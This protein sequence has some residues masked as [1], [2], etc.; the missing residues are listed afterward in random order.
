MR[1]TL[2][3]GQLGYLTIVIAP[4]VYTSLPGM[5]LFIRLTDLGIF[6]VKQ[7]PLPPPTCTKPIPDR[8]VITNADMT[9]PKVNFTNSIWLY[10]KCHVVEL[11]LRNQI[12]DALEP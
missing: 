7:A 9:I 2:D 8:S 1:T 3:R 4:T 5:V 11:A 12:T 10:N 6:A